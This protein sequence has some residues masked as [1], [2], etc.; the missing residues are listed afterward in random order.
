MREGGE[1]EGRKGK[2]SGGSAGGGKEDKESEQIK[3]WK[4]EEDNAA[5]SLKMFALLSP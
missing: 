4:K 2:K 1:N 3:M 5:V